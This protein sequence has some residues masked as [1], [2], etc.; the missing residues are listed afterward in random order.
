[1]KDALLDTIIDEYATVE[2]FASLLAVE[3][4][5]PQPPG[6]TAETA[7]LRCFPSWAAFVLARRLLQHLVEG[8]FLTQDQQVFGLGVLALK[9]VR[10]LPGTGRCFYRVAALAAG[11]SA[12][13]PAPP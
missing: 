1:M 3:K 13:F 5:I 6:Q 2:A 4:A 8:Q 9:L 10:R 11:S 7:D 12:A